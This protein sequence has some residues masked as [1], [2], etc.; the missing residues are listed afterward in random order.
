[1]SRGG[2][3]RRGADGRNCSARPV[4]IADAAVSAHGPLDSLAHAPPHDNDTIM[5]LNR[6]LQQTGC[7]QT[8]DTVCVSFK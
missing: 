1:M 4:F 6:R 3:G 5:T 8:P 7:E 2:T